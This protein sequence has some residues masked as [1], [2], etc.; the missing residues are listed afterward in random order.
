MAQTLTLLGGAHSG[1]RATGQSL[2]A[3]R[4]G[5]LL[6]YLAYHGGWVSRAQLATL[7][8]PEASEVAA[9]RNLRQLLTRVRRLPIAAGLEI[10]SASL[11]W[12]VPT[13]VA[14]FSCALAADDAEGAADAYGGPL[15]E[16]FGAIDVSAFGDWLEIE[17]QALHDQFADA[18]R[19]AAARASQARRHADAAA[20]LRRLVALDPLAEDVLQDYLRTLG[21]AGR[22]EQARSAFERFERQLAAELELEPLE[23][24]REALTAVADGPSGAVAAPPENPVLAPPLTGRASEIELLRRSERPIVVLRGEPGVGKTRLLREA[25]PAARWLQA[26]E[27]LQHVPYW[28][29]VEFLRNHPERAEAI[30][31]YQVDLARVLPELAPD[32]VPPPLDGNVGK[33]RLAEAFALALGGGGSVIVI[34]DL[35]WLDAASIELLHYFA[36]RGLRIRASIGTDALDAPLERQLELL[37]AAGVLEVIELTPL[38]TVA[39]A[40]LLAELADGVA[41][42]AGLTSWLL[43]RSGGNPFFALES[44]R[45]LVAAGSLALGRDGWRVLAP[46]EAPIAALQRSMQ[47][48]ERRLGRLS[49]A[50]RRVLEVCA[51][52]R[53]PVEPRLI[54]RVTGLSARAVADALDRAERAGI[55]NAGHFRHDLFREALTHQLPHARG[56]LAHRELAAAFEG[57]APDDVVAEHWYAAGEGERARLAWLRRV[58][59]LR[60]RGLPDVAADLLEQVLER[61]HD[62]RD[63]A[64]LA[65]R[66]SDALR[67]SGRSDDARRLTQALLE[68]EPDD[69]GVRLAIRLSLAST[70]LMAGRLAEAGAMLSSAD[71]LASVVTEADLRLEHRH[72]RAH[73][74]KA[75]GQSEP[76]LAILAPELPRLRRRRPSLRLVQV[77]TSVAVLYSDLSRHEEALA[78]LREAKELAEAL[79]ARYLQVDIA[80][81]ILFCFS[82]LGRYDEADELAEETLALGEFDNT[83]S[84]RNNLAALYLE[85]GR[86]DAALRHFEALVDVP[87]QAWLRALAR[88]RCAELHVLLGRHDAVRPLLDAALEAL[89]D[90]DFVVVEARVATNVLRYGGDDQVERL[91]RERPGLNSGPYLPYLRAEFAAAWRSRL[92]GEPP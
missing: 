87:G 33:L 86:Y 23:A 75:L 51:L 10:T 50:V 29:L 70:E 85:A 53:G 45:S 41:P 40:A 13:D 20:L 8:W 79:R 15:L 30:G 18:T 31:S 54:G 84:F 16:G 5:C 44:V 62:P 63:R 55:L 22:P 49:D 21:Q 78:T 59:D 43:E 32:T 24:T 69:V 1:D 83:L 46:L 27:G 65:V 17:R 48:V 67:E 58:D 25:L 77:L 37:G 61:A 71:A 60:A 74:S 81:N 92:S 56:R 90:T 52:V 38:D 7:F 28:P 91:L 57:T 2:P 66:R 9:K 72:L 36:K 39:L 82:E 88:A 4:R 42:P 12:A 3:D 73:L 80:L 19:R 6:A 76:A 35:Q 64:W 11:R 89:S 47:I 26:A 34:D 14:R 68:V